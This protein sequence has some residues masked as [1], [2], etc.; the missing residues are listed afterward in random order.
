MKA[1][2]EKNK[3]TLYDNDYY[4]SLFNDGTLH[5]LCIE[6]NNV[7]DNNFTIQQQRKFDAMYKSF[8]A[9]DYEIVA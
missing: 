5:T 3:V 6:N 4:V 8:L 2:I 1:R 9:K 7:K